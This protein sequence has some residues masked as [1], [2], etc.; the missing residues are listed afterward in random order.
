MHANSVS[1]HATEKKTHTNICCNRLKRVLS[2]FLTSSRQSCNFTKGFNFY[3][4]SQ[5]VLTTGVLLTWWFVLQYA[6]VMS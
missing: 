3:F 5:H 1:V 4:L 2:V 6:Y